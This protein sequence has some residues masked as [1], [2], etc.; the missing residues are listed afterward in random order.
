LGGAVD[1]DRIAELARA[2]EH[3]PLALIQAAAYIR[4]RAS[5]CSVGQYLEEFRKGDRKRTG[6]L[7]YDGGRLRRDE[8]AKNSILITWQISF[9]HILQKRRSAADLLS[10]MSFFDRQGIP[11]ALIRNENRTENRHRGVEDSNVGNTNSDSDSDSND[12]DLEASVDDGF[13]E[14]IL[15]LGNYSFIGIT[16]NAGTFNMHG[17]VQ[18]ATRKWLE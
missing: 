13:D 15:M 14:D 7:D 17:L 9:D 3:M 12:S 4:Q 5:R 2:L 10:L 6:L 8:E 1:E 18:L 16:T 11:E